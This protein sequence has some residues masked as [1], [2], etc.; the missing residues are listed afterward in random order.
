MFRIISIG[1]L[2]CF[3]AARNSCAESGQ[4][5][6]YEPFQYKDGESLA[7][8]NGGEGWKDAW[9]G[10]SKSKLGCSISTAEEKFPNL[11][12]MGGKCLLDGSDT[13]IFR[14]IDTDRKDLANL[15]ED[16]KLGKTLGKDGSTI[17]ISF[18]ISCTSF[19]KIAHGGLHLM[20]GIGEGYYKNF[21]RIQ[22]G[23][24]NMGANW[25]LG[26]VDQGGPAAGTWYGKTASD[27]TLRLL[28]YRFDFKAG[29]E[30]AW[31][32]VDPA[33][34]KDPDPA[35][36]EVHAEKVADFRFN[37]VNLGSGGGATFVFD[38]LRIGTSFPKVVPTA[39]GENDKTKK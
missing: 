14:H 30:E 36:A 12:M 37:A 16:G 22:I 28:V 33:P 17:W 23:R 7:G 25:F 11:A 18:L 38:E 8:A 29:P 24:Q 31:M 9:F 34:G 15:V 27:K 20:D 4:L 3:A 19:P 2:M 13:R 10:N 5:I 39:A 32:W 6:A 21:Q 1:L 35:K 26:R